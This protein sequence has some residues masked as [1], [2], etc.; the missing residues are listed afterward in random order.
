MAFSLTDVRL[1]GCLFG[2]S[3]ERDFRTVFHDRTV[4]DRMDL[5]QYCTAVE[6]QGQIGSCTANA[7]V[8]AL[9]Y[10]YKRRDGQSPELSRMFV[11]YNARRMRGQVMMDTGAQIREAMASVMAFGV[12]REE[13]WPYNPMLFAMEPTPVA[14]NEATT[15]EAIQYARV[16]RGQGAIYAL[17]QGLPVVFGT[18][19]PERCYMEAAATGIIPVPRPEELNAPMQGGHSMLIVGY[20]NAER[21]FIVRNSW[22]EEWGDH[23]YCR[24]PYDVMDACSRAEDFWVIAELASETGFR[25]IRPR[26]GAGPATP[27]DRGDEDNREGRRAAQAQPGGIASTAAKM[28]EQIRASLEA[29][30]AASSRKIDSLLSGGTKAPPAPGQRESPKSVLPCN[31]CAGTGICPFCRG[32]AAGC[33]RCGGTG[34]C[35]ECGGAGVL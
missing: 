23:G 2:A 30:L 29:D 6:N 3:S 10:H 27:A 1:N 9:E 16:D 35:Q 34:I 7:A 11:Y 22:G 31:A 18:V 26:Q 12:C 32:S 25:V 14:Y 20:D 19:I 33:A 21:M 17:A 5:R 24:I 28:R 8:G 15:H 4:P 13:I